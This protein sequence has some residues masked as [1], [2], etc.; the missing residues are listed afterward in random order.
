MD[1]E[2][3]TDRLDDAMPTGLQSLVC[4][5]EDEGI[6]ESAETDQSPAKSKDIG[7]KYFESLGEI[8]YRKGQSF[9]PVTNFSVNCTGYVTNNAN[10]TSV[11][12]FMLDVI[13]KESVRSTTDEE[14]DGNGSKRLSP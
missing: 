7:R 14:H 1:E 4:I 12:G 6:P 3:L 2:S 8:G 9:F 10:A 11:D 5:Q 13:P